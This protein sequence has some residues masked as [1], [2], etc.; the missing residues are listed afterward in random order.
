MTSPS[1]PVGHHED[2]VAPPD[3]PAVDAVDERARGRIDRASTV[4]GPLGAAIGLLLWL[5][6]LGRLI[7]AAPVLNATILA[8][9]RDRAVDGT[10]LPDR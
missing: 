5:Y 1:D 6:L 2:Q 3:P 4:Y 10:P 9:R 8:R 7:V